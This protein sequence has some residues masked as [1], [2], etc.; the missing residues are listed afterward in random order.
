VTLVSTNA[1]TSGAS[2][3]VTPLAAISAT[4]PGGSYTDTITYGCVAN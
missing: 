4:T 1:T 3:I 2:V